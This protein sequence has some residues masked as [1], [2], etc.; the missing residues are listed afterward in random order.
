MRASDLDSGSRRQ[1]TVVFSFFYGGWSGFEI[2]PDRPLQ[3]NLAATRAS[4]LLFMA[5]AVTNLGLRY[6]LC[7]FLSFL[8]MG[9]HSRAPIETAG[10]A[11]HLKMTIT[12]KQTTKDSTPAPAWAFWYRSCSGCGRF[13]GSL[14]RFGSAIVVIDTAMSSGISV[15]R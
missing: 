4:R 3:S 10:A 1:K 9:Y 6:I 11:R 5:R 12:G 8:R 14:E 13:S 2:Q 7:G 15:H